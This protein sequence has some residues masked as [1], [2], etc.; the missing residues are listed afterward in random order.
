MAPGPIDVANPASGL[1]P[2]TAQGNAGAGGGA[3]KTGGAGNG[4]SDGPCEV[5][6]FC[7]P[8]VPDPPNC[9][10]LTLNQD[11]EVTRVPGNL[12]VVFDQSVSMGEPWGNTGQTK[13]LAA[14]AAIANAV[15]PLQ[16]AL[17]V[18]ALFFPTTGCF[19]G[20]PQ[21]E[22]AVAAIE[23]PEQI[24]FQPGPMFLKAWAQHWTSAGAGTGVGTPMQEAFDRADAAIKNSKLQGALIVVAVTD[25]QPNC[26][27]ASASGMMPSPIETQHT[28]DW[29]SMKGIKTYMVGLPGAA[30][31]QLLNDVAKSG[32]TMQYLL[33]DD[34]KVLE[35]KLKEAITQTVKMGFATCSIKLTPAANPPEKLQMIVVEAKNGMKSRVDHMLGPDAGWTIST[36]GTQVEIQGQ[37][38]DDAKQGR[39][40]SINFEYGCKDIPPP[41][42]LPPPMIN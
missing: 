13:L 40:S 22:G 30:G 36:D 20:L 5:G 14:Q 17:T 38:C 26:F 33:P 34:P 8:T 4:G 15:M 10:T 16:D 27:P 29:L 39:F 19:A 25:G 31:V 12:L 1:L 23:A 21:P 28:A 2:M 42:P 32:G 37:L 3:G 41:P 24:Q 11:V 18:G 9:G 6:K 7:A 35:A